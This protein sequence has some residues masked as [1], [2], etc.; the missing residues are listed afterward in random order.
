MVGVF[1]GTPQPLHFNCPGLHP[2]NFHSNQ[3]LQLYL[4]WGVVIGAVPVMQRRSTSMVSWGNLQGF[5][6]GWALLIY[7]RIHPQR[8]R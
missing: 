4:E 3:C 2:P 5:L 8:Q 6:V 7:P 1:V